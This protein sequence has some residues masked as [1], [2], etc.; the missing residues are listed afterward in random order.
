[1]QKLKGFPIIEQSWQRGE[2]LGGG[3]AA[4]LPTRHGPRSACPCWSKSS[5]SPTLRLGIKKTSKASSCPAP[6]LRLP[7]SPCIGAVPGT[8]QLSLWLPELR[9]QICSKTLAGLPNTC[10]APALAQ[11]FTPRAPQSPAVSAGQC[12][13][14]E[15]Q[16]KAWPSG[17]CLLSF[18]SAGLQ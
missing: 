5:H 7:L 1:M 3:T 13:H 11:H 10:P 17:C 18:S 9:G 14:G 15:G 16:P 2:S 6:S 12:P 8:S 4:H